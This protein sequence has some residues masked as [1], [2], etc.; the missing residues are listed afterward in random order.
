MPLMNTGGENT[1]LAA[2]PS[3]KLGSRDSAFETNKSALA[4]NELLYGKDHSPQLAY[5][6]TIRCSAADIFVFFKPPLIVTILS[7]PMKCV[8]AASSLPFAA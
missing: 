1:S 7:R 4:S 5:Q 6:R 3:Q 8:F 2:S